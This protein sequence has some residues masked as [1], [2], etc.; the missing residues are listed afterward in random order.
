MP[1]RRSEP[2]RVRELMGQAA[3]LLLLLT[4]DDRDLVAE[5]AALFRQGMYMEVR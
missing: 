4:A 1:A 3:A 2:A 5:F